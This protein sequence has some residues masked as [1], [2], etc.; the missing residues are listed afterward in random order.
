MRKN[1]SPVFM[2][3]LLA[4]LFSMVCTTAYAAYSSYNGSI[5][6][7]QDFRDGTNNTVGYNTDNEWGRQC[8]DGV[9]ILYLRLGMSLSTG[10]VWGYDEEGNYVRL[11][12]AKYCWDETAR[13][14][15]TGTQFTQITRIEDVKRGDV[16]VFSGPYSTGHI[17][18][19]DEDNN[20][21][22]TTITVW[23]QNQEY[24]YDQT[25]GCYEW[26]F[27]SA[28]WKKSYFLGAFRYNGWGV[29]GSEMS[30]GYDRVLPD[31]DY[32]IA[33]AGA[34][35]KSTF[36][37]LDIAGSALP[38]SSETNVSLCGPLTGDP[39]IYEIWT[40]TYN[41]SDKFYTI[42]QK[43]T[44]MCLDVYGAE[45]LQGANVSVHEGNSSSAQKWAIQHSNNGYALRPKCSGGGN[46]GMCLD[47][48]DGII[49]NGTN[50]RTFKGNGSAAQT[51]L[52]I[53]YKPTQTLSNGR[54]IL[55]SGVNDSWELDVPGDTGDVA[56]QTAVWLWEDTAPSQYN[57]FDITKLDNGYYSIIHAAS[58]KALEVY[59]GGSS[60]ETS[61]SLFTP[62]GSNAQQWAITKDGYGGGYTLRVKSSGYAMDLADA[63]LANGTL[64]R[65]FYWNGS[66]AETW[67][68]VQ[69]EY[70]VIYDANG[71]SNAP[72][73]QV[74]FYHNDLTLSSQAPTRAGYAFM[75]WQAN[76]NGQTIN[77]APGAAYS[78]DAD[79][80]LTAQWQTL[81]YT[82]SYDA[83][84]G[85][86]A[87][88]AQTV[89]GGSARLS[90]VKPTREHYTFLGWAASPSAEAAAFIPGDL[91][92][93]G[94]NITLYAVWQQKLENVMVLPGMLTEIEE[95]TFV[96]TSADAFVV[97][98]TVTSIGQNAFDGA[99]VYGYAGSYAETYA[100]AKGLTFIPITNEWVL[101]ETVPQGA[102]ISDEKWTYI[103]TTTEMT[104]SPDSS[105]PGWT[106]VGFEWKKSGSG[107]WKYAS[108]PSGFDT[109][110]ALY[111]KY[112]KSPLS[113][114]A[115]INGNTKRAVGSVVSLVTYIYWHWTLSDEYANKFVND[116]EG[117]DGSY[118]YH[119]F[120]AFEA[121]DLS[122]RYGMTISG[123]EKVFDGLWSTYHYPEYSAYGPWWWY[124]FEVYQ[125]TY[126]DYHKLFTYV[127]DSSEILESTTEPSGNNI[128]NVQHW[129]KYSF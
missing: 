80:T 28:E 7:Y 120:N 34:T 85:T 100:N 13:S 122:N 70:P 81:S 33:A 127:K 35:D 76:V 118:E 82:I 106:Q 129:V 23:G 117:S 48:T 90:L 79:I 19:A 52:F 97:P 61:V 3:S 16:V 12:Y 38:A 31:G 11:G 57:S 99:A 58:G 9:Q 75:G 32:L 108:F 66:Q 4:I 51:W 93:G 42:K 84:G 112:N 73:R 44:N 43:G 46:D 64:V 53:P 105:L 1:I 89:E 87:P 68:F 102:T 83:N 26:Y 10:N 18:F 111:S 88:S 54:Y 59:G 71:G 30:Q 94:V 41:S 50:V 124:R 126:I 14:T 8:W 40:V 113:V 67:K 110:H 69:A 15:N 78:A 27:T 47:I 119:L 24:H 77:Y 107:T 91:Y 109:S 22:K 21:S 74:K 2:L 37:Y 29:R 72:E 123:E 60:T 104:T 39:P 121:G 65:Q 36:Y 96:G 62:N 115:T 25:L 128:S 45:T 55:L 5:A 49:A 56:D 6:T 103:L 98:L 63:T 17:A 92:S 95:E 116:Y 20:T 101:A 86:G 125:Q 114:G